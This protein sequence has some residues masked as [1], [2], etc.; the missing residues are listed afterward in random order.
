MKRTITLLLLAVAGT[1][2]AQELYKRDAKW[3]DWVEAVYA[4]QAMFEDMVVYP[5]ASVKHIFPAIVEMVKLKGAR[6]GDI[7]IVI[8]APKKPSFIVQLYIICLYPLAY[9]GRVYAKWDGK[10]ERKP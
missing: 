5:P 3:S 1:A 4:T 7:W 9:E 2:S 10:V 8:D 6:E